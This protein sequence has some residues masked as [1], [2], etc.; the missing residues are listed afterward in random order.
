MEVFSKLFDVFVKIKSNHLKTIIIVFA[1]ITFI[2]IAFLDFMPNL[3]LLPSI[4]FEILYNCLALI[5]AAIIVLIFS[6]SDSILNLRET[7][8]DLSFQTVLTIFVFAIIS[9]SG[10]FVIIELYGE[11][12]KPL[13]VI[14]S[15]LMFALQLLVA[16]L[17]ILVARLIY[18]GKRS[19]NKL[20]KTIKEMK[21][22]GVKF[23]LERKEEQAD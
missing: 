8:N 2:N 17:L 21:K 18:I 22:Q 10:T 6:D 3:K 4:A 14:T 16:T 12:S 11:N 7:I 13:N 1:I 19:K 15:T 5:L 20:E 23:P 9:V